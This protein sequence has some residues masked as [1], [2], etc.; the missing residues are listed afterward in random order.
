MQLVAELGLTEATNFTAHHNALHQMDS[1][2]DSLHMS[3]ASM[4]AYH[5]GGFSWAAAEA[6]SP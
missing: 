5:V 3:F 2:K 6:A 4:A 1:L